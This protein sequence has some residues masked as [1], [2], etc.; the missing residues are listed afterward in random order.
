MMAE[1]QPIA[2]ETVYYVLPRSPRNGRPRTLYW[3]ARVR[4]V[5]EKC[6]VIVLD[7]APHGHPR[8]TVATHLVRQ[9]PE[10]AWV[11]PLPDPPAS[12]DPAH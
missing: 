1:W 6:V 4:R 7:G 10:G 8:N 12:H 3:R 2:G 11:K 9:P 5:T